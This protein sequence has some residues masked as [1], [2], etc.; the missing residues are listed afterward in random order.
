MSGPIGKA[1]VRLGGV[2]LA[3]TS[4]VIWR[5]TTGTQPYST[6]VQVHKQAWERLQNQVGQPLRLEVTDTRGVQLSVDQVYILHTAPSDSRH[7]VTLVISDKRWKWTYKLVARDY[8]MTRKTGDRSSFGA[9]PIE[10][11]IEVD[12]YDYLPYSIKAD[13]NRWTAREAV[14]DVLK[15]LEPTS[16]NGSYIIDGFPLRSDSSIGQHTLQNVMLRDAGDVALSRLL[17]FVPGADIFIDAS[18]RVVVYDATNLDAADSYFRGLPVSTRSGEWVNMIDRTAIRPA[19]V[20]VHYQ[21]EVEVVFTF[22]DDYLSATYA[23][24]ARGAPFIENVIPTVDPSTIITEYDPQTGAT[25]QKEVPS[26]TWVEVRSWLAAMDQDRPE[27]SLPWTFDTIKTHWVAGDL[28]GVLGGRGLDLDENANVSMRIQALKQH[29]RQTFRIN[30]RYMERVRD[31][32]A[33]RAGLIDP[34]TG[35]RAPAAVWGQAC[36]VPTTKGKYMA[37]RGTPDPDKLKVFRNVDYYEPS[38]AAGT[39]V[40]DTAPG[41]TSVSILDKELGVFRLEWIASPYGTVESFIPCN[42]VDGTNQRAVITRNLAE[43]D[44]RPIA[45]GARTES[46]TNGIFLSGTM[47]YAVILTIIPSAPNNTKQFHKVE[48]APDQI[49]PMFQS[50]LRITNG[51]GPHLE[52]FVTPGEETARFA[53]ED[54]DTAA[55]TVEQLLGLNTDTPDAGIEGPELPGF[56]LANE[57]LQDER[58]LTAHARALAAELYASYADNVQGSVTT[59]LPEGGIQIRGNMASASIRVA[60]APS[61]KVDV[62]HQFPGTQRPISRFALLPDATRVQILGTLPFRE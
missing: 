16:A 44:E 57:G 23:P 5:F 7:R 55:A 8:N 9:V 40:V 21:R 3:G 6:T 52:V 30:R 58:H 51:E 59:R 36:V 38:Q 47:V 31:L 13:G 49:L 45:A 17:S 53:W 18:G 62:L 46:G 11:R 25:E 10:T 4:P 14:E 2:P 43:Q 50:K 60:Q 33:I 12:E 15:M 41:P 32:R 39:S 54:D 35:A 29:F 48:V 1:I 37:V 26:G 20:D 22:R 61:A 27:G 42:L 34:I 24:P 19:V 28:D 56:R